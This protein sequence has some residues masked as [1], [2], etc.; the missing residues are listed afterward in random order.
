MRIFARLGKR[1]CRKQTSFLGVKKSFVIAMLRFSQCPCWADTLL[2]LLSQATDAAVDK[3]LKRLA[4]KNSNRPCLPGT[5]QQP[6]SQEKLVI[7]DL[8]AYRPAST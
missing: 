8:R 5:P 3:L 7:D 4:H 6:G 2:N 1:A